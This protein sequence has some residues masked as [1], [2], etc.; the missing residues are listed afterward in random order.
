MFEKVFGKKKLN[1]WRLA[2]IFL[3]LTITVLF[4]LW[5][6]PQEP[7]AQ[8]MDS[9]MGNMMKQMHLSNAAIYDLLTNGEAQSQTQNQSSIADSHHEGQGEGIIKLNFLTTATIF[10]LLPLIIGGSI[11]LAIVWIK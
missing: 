5:R 3:G 1:F 7:K 6:A 8:M 2:F 11:I 4:F 10:F 9:S